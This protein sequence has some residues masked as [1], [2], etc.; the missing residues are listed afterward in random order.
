MAVDQQRGQRLPKTQLLPSSEDGRPD[1]ACPSW[2]HV[3]SLVSVHCRD[4]CTEVHIATTAS[5]SFLAPPNELSYGG[6]RF[7][8][9]GNHSYTSARALCACRRL[10][11]VLAQAQR[12]RQQGQQDSADVGSFAQQVVD[13]CA[14][15]FSSGVPF[16]QTWTP[17]S[18]SPPLCSTVFFPTLQLLEQH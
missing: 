6:I 11:F 2:F 16:Y 10:Q 5:C 3:V 14:C 13:R 15:V 12:Q 4:L 9:D 17:S 7:A 1:H 8:K 18:W